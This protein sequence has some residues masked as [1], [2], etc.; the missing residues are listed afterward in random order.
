MSTDDIVALP[1]SAFLTEADVIAEV[2]ADYGIRAGSGAAWIGLGWFA[3]SDAAQL[4]V[5][6]HD[7][8]NGACGIATFLAA[9]ARIA[10]NPDSADL[11]LAAIAHLHAALRG[12]RGSRM[13][14]VAGIGGATGLGS[15]IYGLTCISRFL[16]MT[17]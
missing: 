5:L 17:G 1:S 13:G 11:A 4:A 3:D 9:H 14:R 8:Y 12:H 6:G 7:L 16:T 15:I 10:R 2:I